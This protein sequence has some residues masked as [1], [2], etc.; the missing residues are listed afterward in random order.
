MKKDVALT[1]LKQ[2]K[3]ANVTEEDIK[4]LTNLFEDVL[5]LLSQINSGY[6][7]RVINILK[8]YSH[9]EINYSRENTNDNIN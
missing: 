1:L 9:K 3:D 7:T 6:L 2:M 8:D 5:E 4:T